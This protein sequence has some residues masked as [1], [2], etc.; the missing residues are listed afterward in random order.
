MLIL[1]FIVAFFFAYFCFRAAGALT[2][3]RMG[4]K[5][6][7]IIEAVIASVLYAVLSIVET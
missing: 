5:A 3:L 7:F 1:K 4:K 6:P 2:L